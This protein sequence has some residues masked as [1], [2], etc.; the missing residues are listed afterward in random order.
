MEK[1]S[2]ITLI[3]LQI[4]VPV[5]YWVMNGLGNIAFILASFGTERIAIHLTETSK[6]LILEFLILEKVLSQGL[7]IFKKL[8]FIGSVRFKKKFTKK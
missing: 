7:S 3:P 5:S 2:K 6:P 8:R 4:F 1:I